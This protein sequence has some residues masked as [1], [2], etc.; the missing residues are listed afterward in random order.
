MSGDA[1]VTKPD[2]AARGLREGDAFH[3]GDT[4]SCGKSGAM[5][6]V[7]ASGEQ[8]TLGPG[9]EWVVP[10]DWPSSA[11]EHAILNSGPA[12]LD[13]LQLKSHAALGNLYLSSGRAAGL[14][15]ELLE[16]SDAAPDL[17]P[18]TLSGAGNDE[19]DLLETLE[20]ASG[21][22]SAL[23]LFLR[24]TAN[25]NEPLSENVEQLNQFRHQLEDLRLSGVDG[26]TD[27]TARF[28][29]LLE[30]LSSVF[31]TLEH[32]ESL[33]LESYSKEVPGGP[34]WFGNGQAIHFDS[35]VGQAPLM[36]NPDLIPAGQDAVETLEIDAVLSSVT[37]HQLEDVLSFDRNG[38]QLKVSIQGETA[39]S[40]ASM[41]AI[42]LESQ[43]GVAGSAP[44]DT[45]LNSG[46]T[47]P[48]SGQV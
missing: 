44:W 34:A 42:L 19:A 36:E 27:E 24:T 46:A 14:L 37:E 16:S 25:E 32:A 45:V 8:L 41:S 7:T 9:S 6:V 2:G 21:L 29:G 1:S 39:S 30:S 4:V 38:S 13:A 17:M 47:G 40:D 5:L 15:S 33:S 26:S 12:T 10:M 23:E 3:A 28:E 31:Q 18:V 35:Q 22:V 48:E 11:A 20:T 43:V